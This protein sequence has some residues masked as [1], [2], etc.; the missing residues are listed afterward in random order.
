MHGVTYA[1]TLA[2]CPRGTARTMGTSAEDRLTWLKPID[3][4][5]SPTAFSWSGNAYECISTTARESI[6]SSSNA[7]S[8]G[9]SDSTSS[10]CS[11]T[12]A[13]PV[14]PVTI[15]LGALSDGEES[16]SDVCLTRTLS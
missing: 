3:R 2:V 7:C 13:S 4:A 10:G 6:P 16:S 8:W 5:S 1:S 12:I 14:T 15:L 9:R 11:I